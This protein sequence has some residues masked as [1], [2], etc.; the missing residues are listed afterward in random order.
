MI[1]TQPIASTA[2]IPTVLGKV[3][4]FIASAKVAAA[5]GIT[6][7]EFGELLIAFLRLT[8][9]ALDV[10]GGVPGFEKKS[11]ALEGVARLFDAVAVNAVPLAGWPL[12]FLLRPAIRALV[13]SLASGAIEQ[14]L[15]LVRAE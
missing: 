10:L 1:A 9:E 6:W 2:E 4:S 12:W 5:G 13:I 8:V 15:P 3:D 7:V 11:F 14:L